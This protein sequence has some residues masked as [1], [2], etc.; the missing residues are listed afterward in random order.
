VNLRVKLCAGLGLTAFPM[1]ARGALRVTAAES[2][3]IRQ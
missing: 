2:A 1:T 3:S